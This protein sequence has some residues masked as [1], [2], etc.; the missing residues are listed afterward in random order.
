MF[1]LLKISVLGKSETPFRG[2]CD[3]CSR[4]L[5]REYEQL[6]DHFHPQREPFEHLLSCNAKFG[7]GGIVSFAPPRHGFPSVELL[8]CEHPRR[9]YV[10]C[11]SFCRGQLNALNF[12]QH[13]G[14]PLS[15]DLL[16]QYASLH[17][18]A[19]HL[20]AQRA[21]ESLCKYPG[22]LFC[23]DPFGVGELEGANVS[24][25]QKRIGIECASLLSEWRAD[26]LSRNA[27][28][29]DF[30]IFDSVRK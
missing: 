6:F 29:Q 15:A 4:F 5:K 25:L 11:W 13:F 24:A 10:P 22:D 16:P 19:L 20:C 17:A 14:T 9:V 27:E 18:S 3:V 23:P 7:P 21:L 2:V 26:P 1:H 28:R 12:L 30:A 8:D